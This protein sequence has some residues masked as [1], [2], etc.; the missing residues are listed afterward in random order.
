MVSVA[1]LRT[2]EEQIEAI[3]NW[4]KENGRSTV[5]GVTLAVVAVFGWRTWQ[6]Y[7]QTQAENASLLFQNMNGTIQVQPGE[8]L[9]AERLATATHLAKQLKT[10]HGS[11]S[12]ALFASLW[13]AKVA[14]EQGDTAAAQSEQEWV[15]QQ[16]PETAV[17]QVARQR[18]ARVIAAN[19][20]PDQALSVLGSAPASGFESDFY[21]VRGDILLQKGDVEQARA[22]YQQGLA[23]A[24]G[25]PRPIL[26]MKLDDL[27]TGES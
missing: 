17:A 20:N 16:E 23:K 13:L 2:E 14:V 27:A 25:E 10:E 7:Q 6:D 11:S 21:Q 22:A 15:L 26:S 5:L 19:G 12:Y 18:L 8:T 1:D 3:K 9:P 4:W 24:G